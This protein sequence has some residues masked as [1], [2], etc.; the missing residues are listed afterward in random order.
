MNY[1]KNILKVTLAIAL[2]IPVNVFG[3]DKT[4]T[5][6]K[7]FGFSSMP[8]DYESFNVNRWNIDTANDGRLVVNNVRG[9][10][11][12]WGLRILQCQ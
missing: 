12:E 6:G 11:G 8:T 7:Y 2:L 5:S 9:I 3:R 10:G 1:L 4:N